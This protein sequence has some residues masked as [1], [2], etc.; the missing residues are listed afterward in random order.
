MDSYASGFW[1]TL[2]YAKI[3]GGIVILLAS[4]A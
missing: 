2:G 3:G 1:Y 4:V